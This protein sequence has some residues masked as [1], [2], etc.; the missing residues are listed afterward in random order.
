[1]ASSDGVRRPILADS[2]IRARSTLEREPIERRGPMKATAVTA[3]V[4]LAAAAV[5][6]CQIGPTRPLMSPYDARE[7]FGYSERRVNALRYEVSY[8]GPSLRTWLGRNRRAEDV[9]AARGFSHD[10]ALWRAAELATELGFAA[11]TVANSQTDVE[12]EIVDQ[13]PYFEPFRDVA[14]G[15][16]GH[17]LGGLYAGRFHTYGGYVPYGYLNPIYSSAWMQVRVT[18]TIDL[19][20]AGAKGAYDAAATAARLENAHPE[21]LVT[22]EY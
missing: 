2:G 20:G 15:Y 18:L 22:P 9:V 11:F 21:A 16:P 14:H 7:G 8:Q 13:I 10:L 5:A 4:I 1:M 17:H 12:V 3:I 6:A 19:K